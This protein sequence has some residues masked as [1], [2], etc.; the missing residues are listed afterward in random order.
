MI[1]VA[2]LYVDPRGPYP[3]MPGVECWD[4]QRDARTYAG[5]HPVVAHPP[6]QR[7]GRMAKFCQARWGLKVG[8]DGGLFAHALAAV[9]RWG[10]VL[11]HP[12]FSY[13][14][15][16]HDLVRPARAAWQRTLEGEWVCSVAQV[17]Y[18]HRADKNTWLLFAGRE[19]LPVDY[20][21]PSA[22]MVISSCSKRLDG[23]IERRTTEQMGH[24]E[25]R[26]TPPPLRGVSRRARTEGA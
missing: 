16:A 10:G 3:S 7:W 19:P 15:A 17:A 12:A 2:A 26:V 8:E 4:E 5:P 13:A 6:C 11:E 21:R 1:T 25:R 14:W 23:R 18:G 20:S 22:S 24:T 9:R